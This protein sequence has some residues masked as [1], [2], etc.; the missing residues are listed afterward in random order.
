MVIG[1]KQPNVGHLQAGEP[2]KLAAAYSESVMSPQVKVKGMKTP[3]RTTE[4]SLLSRGREPGV[5][6]LQ[7]TGAETHL[8][9]KGELEQEPASCAHLFCSVWDPR[10]DGARYVQGIFLAQ[11]LTHTPAL[12]GNTLTDTPRSTFDELARH[13]LDSVKLALEWTIAEQN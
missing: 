11:F 10:L 8:L 5:W 1:A 2:E 6:G 12:C 7:A 3:P 13:P 4:S 9:G